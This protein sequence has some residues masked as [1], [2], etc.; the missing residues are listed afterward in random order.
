MREPK[1]SIIISSDSEKDSNEFILKSLPRASSKCE[2][3]IVV[4][5]D[6]D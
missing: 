5:S 2:N 6:S 4:S 1:E 3:V